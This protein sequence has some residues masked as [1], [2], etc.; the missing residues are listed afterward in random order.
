[1]YRLTSDVE[2]WLADWSDAGPQTSQIASCA[3]VLRGLLARLTSRAADLPGDDRAFAVCRTL[4][5]D[6]VVVER[7][8]K[9]LVERFGQRRNA[10]LS[11][12]LRAADEVIWSCVQ[13]ARPLAAGPLPVPLAYL[14]PAFSASATPRV[15]P[16]AGLSVRDRQLAEVLRVFP[17][18][19]LGL[20]TSVVSEPWWLA[21]VA[22]EVGHHVQYDLD[23]TAVQR[24]GSELV[25]ATGDPAWEDWRYEVFADAFAVAAL[26]P[27]ALHATAVLEWDTAVAMAAP[28][29]LYPPVIVRLAVMAAVARALG[30]PSVPFG[31]D[32]WIAASAAIAA[33]RRARIVELLAPVDA[34]AQRLLAM[35]LGSG[36]L[37]TLADRASAAPSDGA[38]RRRLDGENVAI[39][40]GRSV[41]RMAVASAFEAYQTLEGV[42]SSEEREQR[43]RDLCARTIRLIADTG[44]RDAKRAAHAVASSAAIIDRMFELL[45][46]VERT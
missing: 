10:A 22:H 28:R 38:L 9:L 35:P 33:D 14:E 23:A 6:I 20:P 26:G 37:A 21:V 2:G 19:L 5:G 17:V 32:S 27:V 4:D 30:F 34:V 15:K 13:Q 43:R 45:R 31:A 16:P 24:T 36:S 40:R 25:Q 3:G 41:P 46:E 18:P 44:A 29:E 1:M 39:T 12:T 7:L 42:A 11:P 8:V